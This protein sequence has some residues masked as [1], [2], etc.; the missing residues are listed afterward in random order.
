MLDGD[1]CDPPPLLS[2]R[3]NALVVLDTTWLRE[4]A[5]NFITSVSLLCDDAIFSGDEKNLS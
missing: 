2:S 5:L 1:A 4:S 3:V